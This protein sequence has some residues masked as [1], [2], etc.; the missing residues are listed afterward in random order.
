MATSALYKNTP[1]VYKLAD[2]RTVYQGYDF[3]MVPEPYWVRIA[4]SPVQWFASREALEAFLGGDD[5]EPPTPSAVCPHCG[6]PLINCFVQPFEKLGYDL[7]L[8]DCTNLECKHGATAEDR[9]TVCY[10]KVP[11]QLAA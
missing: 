4:D 7:L 3:D 10:G 6:Q 9:G 2:G 8:G 1:E 5:P 11:H